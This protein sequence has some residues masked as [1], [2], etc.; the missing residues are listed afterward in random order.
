MEKLDGNNQTRKE[1]QLPFETPEEK[2]VAE[3][4]GS[5]SSLAVNE[6]KLPRESD[7]TGGESGD[8]TM[9]ENDDERPPLRHVDSVPASI[10]SQPNGD[11]ERGV[12]GP[13]NR[14]VDEE[15]KIV[16]NWE[17]KDDPENP[18]NWP[19]RKK[20]FNVVIISSMTF[21]C[22]LCSAMFVGFPFE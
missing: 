9:T 18:K 5:Q 19:K 16:V 11:L 10:M 12:T 2:I 6:N 8:S 3:K 20:I 21:L 17:S 13:K 7:S 1:S 14:T 4:T 15:G 22:P